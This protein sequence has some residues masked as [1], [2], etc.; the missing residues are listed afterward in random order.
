MK[1]KI[2]AALF[3]FLLSRAAQAG[4]IRV[5]VGPNWSKYL[6]SSE[7]DYLNRQQKSGFGIGLGW[8]MAVNR[9]MKLEVN[10]LFGEK[11]AKASL[12]Y[13]PG[14]TVPGIYKNAS[15]SFPFL[16]KYQLKEKATPYAALG[17]EL[18]FIV[19]HHLR[20]PESGDTI[21][22]A[23]NTRKIVLAFNCSAGLRMAGRALEPVRRDPL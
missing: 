20:L 17:P 12:E 6:F 3:L 19:S 23:D 9:N 14:K 18:V 22:I 4:E 8:A 7:I 13:S 16:F 10:A 21:N 2:M 1:N 5:M 11:G 15:I